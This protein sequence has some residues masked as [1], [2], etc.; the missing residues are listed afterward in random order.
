[1]ESMIFLNKTFPKIIC[2]FVSSFILM[3]FVD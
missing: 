3:D 1:M 2:S